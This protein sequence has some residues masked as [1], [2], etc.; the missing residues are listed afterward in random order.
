MRS[1]IGQILTEAA[2]K[3]AAKTTVSDAT[4]NVRASRPR[5]LMPA[6]DGLV[7][8]VNGLAIVSVLMVVLLGERCSNTCSN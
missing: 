4:T 1:I 7:V 6:P 3:P 2:A 8:D 5:R